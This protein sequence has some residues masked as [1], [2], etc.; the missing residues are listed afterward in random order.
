M[1]VIPCPIVFFGAKITASVLMR[2]KS[3]GASASG[4][5]EC[6]RPAVLAGAHILPLRSLTTIRDPWH[7]ENS[8]PCQLANR[9]LLSLVLTA[10]A[11]KP[12][13]C[14]RPLG[15]DGVYHR[16]REVSTRYLLNAEK[17]RTGKGMRPRHRSTLVARGKIQGRP[18]RRPANN[19]RQALVSI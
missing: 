15:G 9:P 14:R 3:R 2:G 10:M 7:C 8:R 13:E 12:S 11:V 16:R 18:S 1:L 19:K 17:E 4:D 5:A 6:S